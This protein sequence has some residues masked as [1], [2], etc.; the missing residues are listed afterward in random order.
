VEQE[1]D[2]EDDSSPEKIEDPNIKLKEEFLKLQFE[3]EKLKKNNRE[4]PKI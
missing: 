2:E 1:I 4:K 3:L